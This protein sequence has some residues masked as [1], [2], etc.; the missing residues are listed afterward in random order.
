MKVL[1]A[2]EM[3]VVDRLTTERYGIPS[4]SLME[5][6]GKNVALLIQKRFTNLAQRRVVV[7]CGKGNNGGDGFV[8]ARHLAEMGARPVVYLFAG[9]E[10]I[11]G[12]AAINC[13]RWRNGSG[14]LYLA[15][16][17]AEWQAA[18]AAIVSVDLIVDALLG[19]GVR[20]PV[21]GS[22]AGSDRR[23]ESSK[24]RTCAGGSYQSISLRG[25]IADTGE[26]ESVAVAAD[27][28]VTF[29][30]PKLGLLIGSADRHVGNVSVVDIG[31]PA[32]L[33]EEFGKGNIR[34]SEP[35]EFADFA[36]PR[37]P[38]TNKGN[39]GHA[40][41]VAGAVGKSGAAVL[42]SRAVLR[43]GAGLV[44]V[45]TPEPVLSTIAAHTPEIMTEPLPA[46]EAGTISVRTFNHGLFER[47][48]KK[49]RSGHRSGTW[50]RG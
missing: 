27:Y 5:N 46:T 41:I 32:E 49:G 26:V 50:Y 40:L 33:V 17:S 20:G 24:T 11:Q 16:N 8:A 42:A 34:W 48:L 28:T 7:L 25:L 23:R 6:A 29:T 38:G 1:T 21:E 43:S 47:I 22:A 9:I 19:T 3:K 2:P 30:A 39:Y 18:K 36:Q 10:E 13:Q 44:T 14:Q 12:D 31:S 37:K 15:R 35:R 4:L 45:A